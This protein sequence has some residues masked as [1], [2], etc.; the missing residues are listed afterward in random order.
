ME[1]LTGA[2]AVL[3]GALLIGLAI[4][5]FASVAGRYFFSKPVEGD[6]EFVKMATAIGV[7]AFLPYAQQ[8]RANIMVDT[9]TGWMPQGLQ[10]AID[11][12]WDMVF[13]GFMALCAYSLAKGT[14]EAAKSGET[15][16]ML[17]IAVWPAIAVCALLSAVV[18]LAAVNTAIKLIRGRV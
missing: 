1:K 3:G 10:R 17:Q 7:F 9:F 2:I 5:V 11:A 18:T 4:L 14:L 6:F 13:A 8:R 15:T 12:V 16:M